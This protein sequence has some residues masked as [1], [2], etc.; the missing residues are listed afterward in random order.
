MKKLHMKSKF[1][2]KKDLEYN[3]I[4]KHSRDGKNS[5]P[6]V[7][8]C[9]S[10]CGFF[11]P[12]RWTC[13]NLFLLPIVWFI[14]Y[15]Y[16]YIYI[17]MLLSSSKQNCLIHFHRCPSAFSLISI[18]SKKYRPNWGWKNAS[19]DFVPPCC[20]PY[21]IKTIM[22]ITTMLFKNVRAIIDYIKDYFL[23]MYSL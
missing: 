15:I 14:L 1:I 18:S 19:S 12:Q 2:N 20:H 8:P 17:Y 6:P 10:I 23:S 4:I 16:I 3:R 21:N 9:S 5:M 13:P 7:L 11:L 22:K